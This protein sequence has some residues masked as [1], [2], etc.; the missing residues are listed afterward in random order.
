MAYRRI[1]PRER[2]MFS[3]AE[4]WAEDDHL[5]SVLSRRI[6]SSY[7]RFPLN[8]I[9]GITV[10]ALPH[11]TV[12]QIAWL[13]STGLLFAL[14]A[15]APALTLFKVA[16]GALTV[17]PFLIALREVL[18]GP[19][20]RAMLH[21]A[22]GGH[23]LPAVARR[24]R[25]QLLLDTVTPLI[26]SV[27]GRTERLEV[28]PRAFVHPEEDARVQL[29]QHRALRLVTFG[30]LLV[31]A[32]VALLFWWRPK[33]GDRPESLLLGLGLTFTVF[34]LLLVIWKNARP[35]LRKDRAYLLCGAAL[36]LLIGEFVLSMIWIAAQQKITSGHWTELLSPAWHIPL[37]LTGL[38]LELRRK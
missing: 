21:T 13:A 11:W 4:L 2:G 10:T 5:L 30:L 31:E 3:Y 23:A 34:A 6:S 27:Q 9:Q 1:L 38:A 22:T 7:Q 29:E 26:E 18:R 20:C 24:S 28:T 17:W 37:A 8:E 25:G 33:L 35:V 15:V 14:S 16:L 32:A 19:R 36:G 12:P